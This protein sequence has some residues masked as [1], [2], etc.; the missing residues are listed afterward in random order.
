MKNIFI[1]IVLLSTQLFGLSVTTG[2][3]TNITETSATLNGD[4]TIWFEACN[5]YFE[6][7]TESGLGGGN[8]QFIYLATFDGSSIVIS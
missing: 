3:A 5:I 6:W 8:S 1:G 4:Y 2:A 7:G